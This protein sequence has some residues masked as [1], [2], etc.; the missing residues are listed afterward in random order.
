M[1]PPVPSST[2]QEPASALQDLQAQLRQTQESLASHVDKIRT[3]EGMLAEHEAIK[4]EVSS[5]RELMEERKREMELL[6]IQSQSPHRLRRSHSHAD[7]QGDGDYSHDDDDARSIATVVPHEL[8]RVEEEDEEQI[9][10][11][12]EEEERRRRRD[13]L[14]RPR[15]P[16]PTGMGMSEDDEE[17][18]EELGRDNT[19]LH[20]SSLPPTTSVPASNAVP[21]ELVHRMTALASQLESALELSRSLEAQHATA[22]TTISTLEAKVSELESLVKTTQVQV[23]AQADSQ[24]HLTEIVEVRLSQQGPSD[25]ERSRERETLTE[26][27]SEWKKGVEGQWSTVQD[28]WADER[29]RMRKAKEEVDVRL[30]NIEEGVGSNV[31]KFETGLATLVALQAQLSRP[32]PNG[33][34]KT[35]SSGGLVTPPSPR[36]LSNASTRSRQRKRRSSSGSGR[37]RSRSASPSRDGTEEDLT[38]SSPSRDDLSPSTSRIRHRLPWM[39]DDSASDTEEPHANGEKLSTD[40]GLQKSLSMQYPITPEPSLRDQPVTG[41]ANPS[42]VVAKPQEEKAG[43][44]EMVRYKYDLQLCAHTDVPLAAASIT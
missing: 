34:A 19:H 33:S 18:D 10:A 12:E 43:S 8:E 44:R 21:D 9:A 14:G 36:S 31:S 4:R 22:Q 42:S 23:Q 39:T 5:M 26:M 28:E 35:R 7:D 1:P 25:D 17:H 16:E 29:D 37:S 3:L 27:F 24:Q 41:L 20:P 11:E 15:T 30:R 13:E 6:R 40:G 32:H 2:S 38:T